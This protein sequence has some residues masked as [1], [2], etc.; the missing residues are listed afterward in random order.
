VEQQEHK[1]ADMPQASQDTLEVEAE[2]RIA[3]L[4]ASLKPQLLHAFESVRDATEPEKAPV[5]HLYD[6]WQSLGLENK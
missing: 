4:F 3:R 2:D 1:L 6:V 5:G